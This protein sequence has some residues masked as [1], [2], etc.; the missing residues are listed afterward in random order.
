MNTTEERDSM[1]KWMSDEISSSFKGEERINFILGL[2]K[3]ATDFLTEYPL[4]IKALIYF[5][6]L[7]KS[8]SVMEKYTDNLC[9]EIVKKLQ[10]DLKDEIDNI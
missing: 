7:E 4:N 1:I 5:Y 10:I 2:K 8:K 9:I 3:E 6:S